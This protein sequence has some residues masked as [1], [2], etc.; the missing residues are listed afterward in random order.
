MASKQK[1]K[2]FIKVVGANGKAIRKTVYVDSN[3]VKYIY[4]QNSFYKL[5]DFVKGRKII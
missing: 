1:T 4:N 5:D 2:E 3:G